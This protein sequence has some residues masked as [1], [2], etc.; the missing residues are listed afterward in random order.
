MPD[1]TMTLSADPNAVA[2][3]VVGLFALAASKTQQVGILTYTQK[4]ILAVIPEYLA[5]DSSKD[6]VSRMMTPLRK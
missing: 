3:V 5:L 4:E 2:D 1:R 6:A